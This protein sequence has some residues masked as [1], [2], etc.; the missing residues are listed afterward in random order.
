VPSAL[1]ALRRQR[2]RWTYGILQVLWKHRGAPVRRGATNVGR[3]GLPYLL[4]F[5]YLLPLLSPAVDAVVVYGLIV[6]GARPEVVALFGVVTGL[7]LLAAM[8]ALRLDGENI[9]WAAGTLPMQ[10]GYRQF[11]SFVTISALGAAV[12]GFPVSWGKLRRRG[13]PAE[14][15]RS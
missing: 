2:C 12:A 5:G 11:L 4:V 8:F 6:A 10:L 13:L 14:V 7:Q 9:A 15:G 1:G 3:L